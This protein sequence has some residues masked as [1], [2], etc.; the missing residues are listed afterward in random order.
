VNGPA[1]GAGFG[2]CQIEGL[3]HSTA[4]RRELAEFLLRFAESL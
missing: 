3:T 1:F 2:F 4:T